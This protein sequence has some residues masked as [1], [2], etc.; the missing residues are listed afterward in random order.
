MS[1]S[2]SPP[3]EAHVRCLPSLIAFR[4]CSGEFDL[5]LE[6]SAAMSRLSWGRSNLL[7][8]ASVKSELP[9]PQWAAG[10]DGP[11]NFCGMDRSCH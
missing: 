11:S 9:D 4:F 8:N 2:L 10:R 6:C 7:N 3:V 5:S 1:A